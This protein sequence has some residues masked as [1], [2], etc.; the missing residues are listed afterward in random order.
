MR[1]G[2]QDVAVKQIHV[3]EDSNMDKLTEARSSL[4]R[5]CVFLSAVRSVK[6]F[7]FAVTQ[8]MRISS[9]T[10]ATGRE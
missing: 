4:Q 6:N 9:K 7:M 10:T 3:R 5:P 1:G 8:A 2:V